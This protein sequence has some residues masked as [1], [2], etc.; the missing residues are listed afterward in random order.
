MFIL[1][2][3]ISYKFCIYEKNALMVIV[4][5]GRKWILPENDIA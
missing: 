4:Y 5:L 3:K 1:Y 2:Y